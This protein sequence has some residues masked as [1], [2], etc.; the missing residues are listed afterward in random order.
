ML[1][2]T[3][4][5]LQNVTKSF[6]LRAERRARTRYRGLRKLGGSDDQ[7]QWRTG[8]VLAMNEVGVL[9]F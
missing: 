9:R 6:E 1:G 2:R 3:R 7:R 8:F 5:A 4:F